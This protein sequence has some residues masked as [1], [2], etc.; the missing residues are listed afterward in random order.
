M[1]HRC[2]GTIPKHTQILGCTAMQQ[3]TG[4]TRFVNVLLATNGMVWLIT[5]RYDPCK[6]A[7][8]NYLCGSSLGKGWRGKVVYHRTGLNSSN[9]L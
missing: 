7:H 4:A 2:Y 5:R 1:I 8:P 9:S 3:R 6:R